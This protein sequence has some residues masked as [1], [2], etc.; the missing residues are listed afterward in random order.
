[1][2][3]SV[4]KEA[5]GESPGEY[6]DRLLPWFVLRSVPGIGNHLFKRLLNRF[7]SPGAVLNADPGELTETEGI[8]DRLASLIKA[9]RPTDAVLREMENIIRKQYRIITMKD[10]DYPGLLLQI[11]DPPPFLYVSGHPG[12]C[13]ACIAV[14]GTRNPTRYGIFVTRQLCRDLA[15]MNITV[16]SGMARGIDTAAHT[17][18]L[19]AGG[20]TIAVLGSGFERIYPAE[21]MELFHRISASGAVMTE[22]PLFAG[23]EPHHFP[24]RNRIISGISLGTVVVEASRRSGSLI[25]ARLAAEQDREVFAVPGNINSFQSAGPHGLIRQGAKLVENARDIADELSH[26]LRFHMTQDHIRQEDMLEKLPPLTAEEEKVF[27]A[28]GPYP[29][30]IDEL[31]RRLYM[32]P[33]PVSALLL[34]LEL[35]GVVAQSPGKMFSIEVEKMVKNRSADSPDLFR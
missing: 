16:V 1:M 27:K 5:T 29:V 11:P 30:H 26:V 24:V 10:P 4:R 14:V 15:A 32:E 17:G 31:V 18:T 9:H 33:G 34:Q 7:Q 8:S 25:T 28:L 21:N 22:F 20:K 19:D 6:R 35:K 3:E 2:E 13:T 23:P 12:N